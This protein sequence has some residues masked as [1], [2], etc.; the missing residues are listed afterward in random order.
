MIINILNAKIIN[1]DKVFLSDI[2]IENGKILAL[3]KPGSLALVKDTYSINA[4]GYFVFPGGIDP[5]V[6]LNLETPAGF[7]ADDF[8]TGSRAALAG[9][10]TG[11]I[12]FIT[13]KRG[14]NLKEAIISRRN[15]V[16]DCPIIPHF[17]MGISGLLNDIDKQMEA[18]VKEYG[19]KSFK[20]YLAYR[21]NIGV[22]YEELEKVMKIAKRLNSIV[23]VHAEEGDVIDALR[24]KFIEQGSTH[25]RYHALSRPPETESNAVKKV[26]ELIKKTNC[27]TYFVHISCAESADYI[28]SAKQEG[29]PVYAET[30]P[31]YLLIDEGVYESE[32]MQSAKYVYSPPARPPE[33]K[34]KLWEHLSAGTF[35]TVATDHCPFTMK[36]K[37]KGKDNFTLIPNGAGGLEF[38]I[39]LMYSAGVLKNKISLNKWIQLVSSNAANIFGLKNK[40][41]IE[42]GKDADITIFDPNFSGIISSEKQYQNSDINIYEG[43][44]LKGKVE[45]VIKDGNPEF[46]NK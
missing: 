45:I 9:G 37:M 33:H 18:C 36:Q 28:L 32:F 26:I 27:T 46:F 19:I 15:E 8:S 23:L 34:D 30:C 7:S 16:G 10:V 22:N 4:N 12:D 29:L 43:F 44:N 1:P 40:Q 31:Q 2:R 17:H 14:Q 20:T 13:P 41:F 42:K 35:D 5:H 24:E 21:Q 38:R 25:P 3:E 39:P 11:L 6:H